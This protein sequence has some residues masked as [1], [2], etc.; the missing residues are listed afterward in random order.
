M[1][2]LDNVVVFTLKKIGCRDVRYDRL[3]GYRVMSENKG[4]MAYFCCYMEKQSGYD[5]YVASLARE[6]RGKLL[7]VPN[8]SIDA[9]SHCGTILKRVQYLARGGPLYTVNATV[10]GDV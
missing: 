8:N 7:L 10:V 6:S 9:Y 3:G 1:N 4:L 5:S 2:E